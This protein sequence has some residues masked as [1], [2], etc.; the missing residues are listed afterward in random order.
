MCRSPLLPT[1]E[2]RQWQRR[3]QDD[4]NPL[5]V[6]VSEYLGGRCVP[7]EHVCSAECDVAVFAKLGDCLDADDGEENYVFANAAATS[8]A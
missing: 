7:L 3:I 2:K 6:K 5:I 8:E 1:L 4:F